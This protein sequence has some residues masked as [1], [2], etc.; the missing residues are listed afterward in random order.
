MSYKIVKCWLIHDVLFEN[1]L[2]KQAKSYEDGKSNVRSVYV[3]LTKEEFKALKEEGY[4]PSDWV[5]CRIFSS[6]KEALEN[7]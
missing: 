5:R 7:I 6:K 3:I 2:Y 1:S 4:L